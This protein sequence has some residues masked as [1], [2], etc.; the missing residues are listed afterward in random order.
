MKL[1]NYQK[2]GAEWLSK[3]NFGLLAD[4][5]RLGKSA[6][7]ISAANIVKAD[8]VLVICRAVGVANW[9]TEIKKW[10]LQAT[11]V[12]VTSY[13]SASKYLLQK[14]DLIIVD[15]CH[16]IK[17]IDA[18]RT[19]V[20]LGTKG[21]IHNTKRMWFLSGTPAP[22]HAGELW[23]ILYTVGTTNL[24]YWDFIKK[25]CVIRTTGYGDIITGTKMDAET[26]ADL[27]TLLK[28]IMLRRSEKDV[29]IE[30]PK[31]SF[32]SET[33]A[34]GKVDLIKSG[35]FS[36]FLE[37]HTLDEL[38]DAIEAEYGILIDV[39]ENSTPDIL[40]ETLK[41]TAKSISTLRKFT[42]LQKVEAT[43][44]LIKEELENK[45][46]EKI[47]IF[48]VH[49]A[50]VMALAEG[51]KDFHPV[52]VI[53][54]SLNKD[55]CVQKFQD[56]NSNCKVFIGNINAAGTSISLDAANQIVFLEQSWV[57]GD[58]AQ[59]AMRCGGVRQK[60]PIFVRTINL[61]NSVDQKVA[62]ILNRKSEELSQII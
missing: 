43:V 31:I 4:V 10:G 13:E 22:N 24:K 50:A 42:A 51:L 52:I 34:A 36:E 30:L 35:A 41:A 29:E 3:H 49:R 47:V 17:S 23:P 55:E 21:L 46:Y 61:P 48:C 45:A 62:T 12:Q 59:A 60:K 16:Y 28:K 7:A 8:R 38:K 58:N 14:W 18:K 37:T 15:E 19:Q 27:K 2:I 11:L 53:G 26:I 25:F 6:Q 44:E 32:T 9:W 56:P 20:V 54:G 40:I 57:P 39:L 33:V 1:F 5:Q